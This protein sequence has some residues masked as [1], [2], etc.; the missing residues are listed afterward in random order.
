MSDREQNNVLENLHVCTTFTCAQ[1]TQNIYTLFTYAHSYHIVQFC[2]LFTYV[3]CIHNVH[4][5]IIIICAN[6]FNKMF[7]YAYFTFMFS[8]AHSSFL[9][10]VHINLHVAQPSVVYRTHNMFMY[11]QY[12]SVHIAHTMLIKNK[13][14]NKAILKKKHIKIGNI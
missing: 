11:A 8:S 3:Q 9:Y 12:S 14:K 5:G 7:M 4:L 10:N 6:C 1:V 13:N 2:T